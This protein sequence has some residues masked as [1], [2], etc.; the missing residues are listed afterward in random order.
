MGRSAFAAALSLSLVQGAAQAPVASTR[1]AI[2]FRGLTMG[3]AF[4]VKVVT[5]RD[6]LD[7]AGLGDVD[8]ALRARLDRIDQLMSTWDRD[9]E[10]SRF[11]RSTSLEPFPVSLETFEVLKWSVDLAA[12]TGGALDVTIGP[13]VDAWGFGPGGPRNRLPSDEEIARLREATGAG[14]LELNSAALTVRKTRPE[15][16]CD[17]SAVAPGYAADRLWAELADRGFTDFLVD[18][19]GELRTRG[20]NDVGE[21]WEIAIERPQSPGHAIQRIVP[22]SNLA[23]A[24][25]GDYRRYRE[26]DGRRFS[27][28]LDPRTGRPLAHRLASVTV[29]DE[30]AVRAD[31]LATALMVLGTGEGMALAEK[32]DLAVLFIERTDQGFSER[33][34]KRFEAITFRHT[35][36]PDEL[37]QT[38]IGCAPFA[39]VV[40]HYSVA[41]PSIRYSCGRRLDR[42]R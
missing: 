24:T 34:T 18:V 37:D 9:S 41:E 33:A 32:M 35:I 29:I 14:R 38:R 5:D 1:R 8:R 42:F 27:H 17:V 11:N 19:G 2:E 23:I 15:V 7:T 25:S 31:G 39:S 21:A 13:L 30:L 12:L 22:V 20:R 4:S 40:A 6:E 10:L 26:V 36:R 28:I 16:R 3:A